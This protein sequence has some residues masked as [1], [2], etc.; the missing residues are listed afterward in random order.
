MLS[1]V[2]A[3]GTAVLNGFAPFGASSATR[4]AVV[5]WTRAHKRAEIRDLK[6][7]VQA[8]WKLAAIHFAFLRFKAA[9]TRIE[10]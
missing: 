10:L 2:P 5:E 7:T 4:Q 6:T 8:A 9:L 1:A 3:S